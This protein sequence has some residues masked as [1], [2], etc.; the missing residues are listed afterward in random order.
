MKKIEKIILM[1][2]HVRDMSR[3]KNYIVQN[4][5]INRIVSNSRNLLIKNPTIKSRKYRINNT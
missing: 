1:T 4:N 2:E 5:S 3:H